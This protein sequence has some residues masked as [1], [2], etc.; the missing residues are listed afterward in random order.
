[1]KRVGIGRAGAI[2]NI[3]SSGIRLVTFGYLLFFIFILL[4]NGEQYI[5]IGIMFPLYIFLFSFSIT[6]LIFNIIFLNSD[7]INNNKTILA[8]VSGILFGG[9][10]GIL[11]GTLILCIKNEIEVPRPKNKTN[12]VGMA[13]AI[14]SIIFSSLFI[15]QLIISMFVYSNL[16]LHETPNE[17]TFTFITIIV[18][19]ISFVL[20][21]HI[22]T[23]IFN[24]KFLTNHK[25][26]IFT[27][28]MGIIFG[29]IIGGILVLCSKEEVE[30]PHSENKEEQLS[31][32]NEIEVPH[33]KNKTN[34]TENKTNGIGVAGAI[35]SII[36]SSFGIFT[37]SIIMFYWFALLVAGG[38][39]VIF[40]IVAIYCFLIVLQIV[41]LI[42]NI[43]FLTNYKDKNFTGIM[44]IFFGGMI[45]GILVLCS[46]EEVKDLR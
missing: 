7:N 40:F 43:K 42:F 23:L 31:S 21:L 25:N 33:P 34:G 28:I 32:K 3:I 44:G 13:G 11:G 35:L 30:N 22:V 27:G 45:G 2:L 5:L 26:K 36:F 38:S 14:L 46:K 19:L 1:M 15:F 12:G 29:G 17:E 39:T 24:I 16:W 18:L 6:T 4:I 9:I 20:I 8:G 41:T 10:I 37:S